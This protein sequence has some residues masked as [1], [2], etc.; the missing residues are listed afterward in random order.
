M[1][2]TITKNEIEK[3]DALVKM[4]SSIADISIQKNL[5]ILKVENG[6]LK[7]IIY[8]NGNIVE[9]ELTVSDIVNT[10]S[11]YFYA[12]IGEFLQSAEKVFISSGS[13]AVKVSVQ[14]SKITV[15]AGKSHITKNMFESLSEAEYQE[16]D[17]AFVTKSAQKFAS[18][19]GT[20]K[21]T[22]EL[23]DFSGVVSKF[24]SMANEKNVTGICVEGDKA[25]YFDQSLAVI[26]KTLSEKVSDKRLYISKNHFDFLSKIIKLEPSYDV[27]YS[28]SADYIKI[29][30]P[31]ANFNVILSMPIV[32]A[33]YPT[34]EEKAQILPPED[35]VFEFDI[36]IA[37]FKN[38]I[39]SFDG[40]FASSVWRYKEFYFT[41]EK[42]KTE[43]N[44]YYSNANAEVDTDLE[45]QNLKVNSTADK[46][47]FKM[48]SLIVYDV[49]T[50]LGPESGTVHCVCSNT[51]PTEDDFSGMGIK[52]TIPGIEVITSKLDEDE[53]I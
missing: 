3:L 51:S 52:F 47:K 15:S 44:L 20:L 19:S 8:G 36:D 28:D 6:K 48:S 2:F 4:C 33:E 27:V 23:I 10:G 12:D 26:E 25:M 9:F 39:N 42:D 40:V 16:A 11:S 34:D 49:L 43:A 50:K 53:I 30:I 18:P 29:S 38:K 37:T 41:V 35:D 17:G 21:M 45:I 24:L 22:N 32:I 13:S 31:T 14:G 1:D 5:Y 46:A 7:P